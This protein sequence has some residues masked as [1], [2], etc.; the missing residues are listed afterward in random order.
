MGLMA[1][2][3]K[4]EPE[5]G[6]AFLT[7]ASSR[8][9]ISIDRYLVDCGKPIRVPANAHTKYVKC[10]MAGQT[11]PTDDRE[12][13]I[14]QAEEMT[15]VAIDAEAAEEG[16]ALSD[17]PDPKYGERTD[18][19]DMVVG[20]LAMREDVGLLMRVLESLPREY[21][22]VLECRFFEGKTLVETAPVIFRLNLTDTE[23]TRE[24]IRQI[25][26]EALAMLRK[27]YLS[28]RPDV[29]T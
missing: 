28:L 29:R 25:E 20:M 14:F 22:A 27:R 15:P 18:A 2:A 4:F 19:A 26:V 11:E 24:R 6:L 23:V 8:V 17:L 13:E 12:A 3:K 7:Y 9:R 16:A 10:R 21:R 1:A 5:R